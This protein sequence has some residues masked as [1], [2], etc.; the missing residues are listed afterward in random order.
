MIRHL[1]PVL[2]LGLALVAF[3]GC[4]DDDDPIAGPTLTAVA[5]ASGPAAGGTTITLTGTG[6]QNNTPGTNSVTVGGENA[7]SVVVVSDTTITC[8]TPARPAGA[9]DVVVSNDNGTATLAGG[10]TAVTTP[11][12]ATGAYSLALAAG[13]YIV[14]AKRP[15]YDD[16]DS[17][18]AVTVVA[19]TTTT[20]DIDLDPLPANTYITTENCA[21]CHDA[22]A[23]TFSRTAHPYKISKVVN[24]TA[25]TF[26]F[27][28]I[29]SALAMITDDDGAMGDPKAGTDNTLG[30]P[31]TWGDL[32]YV[33]GGFGWKARFMDGDG[34]IVTGSS[35]QFNLASG[36]MSAYHDNETDKPFNCGNC[37]TTGWRHQDDTLNDNRQ[38]GLPGMDGTFAQTGIQ[39]ESCHGAGST[40]A[41]TML[42]TDIARMPD[43]RTT[44]QLAAS[45]QGY[46][47]AVHC[48]ECHTRDGEK[49]YPT[50]IS[51][52]SA[53]GGPEEIGG[54]IKASGGLV[55]HHEQ[56]DELLGVDPDD[57]VNGSTRSTAF[58]NTHLDCMTCHS[59]H[60]TTVY[61]DDPSHSDADGVNKANADCMVC[62]STKDPNLR[63]GG[64][65]SLNCVDC[66][67]PKM[68]KSAL[69]T[70][71][72]NGVVVGDVSSHIFRIDLSKD[73]ATEQF[74]AAGDFAY[75]YITGQWACRTCHGN[76]GLFDVTLPSTFEFHN[77][78]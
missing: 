24:S 14:T 75:P 32:T 49:D 10:G 17:V 61:Q 35:V 72:S 71:L 1:F 4:S 62:H 22:I 21:V 74:T 19:D 38:D 15:G 50:Y 9:A 43:P 78:D 11:T 37:H 68:A 51:A 5:P 40:H 41:Q 18:T 47:R 55:Q 34:F 46:G 58:K 66:H 77:N 39:C 28:D 69:A 53:A 30:T 2:L 54:R 57:V 36:G 63:S 67:M 33:I 48:G 20:F 27:S 64:M 60:T 7:T 25:P 29:S 13:D 8:D 59:P 65:K 3:P 42:S 56:Y 31:A 73:P 26:P 52:Y 23:D 76:G 12:D 6:F 45:D 70:T 44:A 16:F